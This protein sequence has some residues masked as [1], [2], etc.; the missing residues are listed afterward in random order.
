MRRSSMFRSIVA[1][2][3]VACG[4]LGAESLGG[5]RTAA[6]SDLAVDGIA[7]SDGVRG[8]G[9]RPAGPV[10]SAMGPVRLDG[11]VNMSTSGARVALPAS[12]DARAPSA[13]LDQQAIPYRVEPRGS[14]G[15]PMNAFDLPPEVP[16]ERDFERVETFDELA[17]PH[18]E[19]REEIWNTPEDLVTGEGISRYGGLAYVPF[20]ARNAIRLGRFSIFPFAHVEGVWHSDLGG[21]DGKGDSGF[22]VQA[23]AGVLAEYLAVQGRTKFKASA[24]ADYRWYSDVLDDAVTYVGGI[25]VEQR[26]LRFFTVDAGVEFERAQIPDDLNTSLA[27]D[28]NRIERLSVYANGRWDRFVSDDMR[29]E[30]GGS[31]AWIDDL[32]SS[33]RNGGDYTDLNLYGRLGYAI[34]RHESFAYGEYRYENRDA[35]GASSDLDYAHEFRLGVNGILPHGRVRRLVGNAWV[36]YRTEQYNAS[37]TAGSLGRGRDESVDLITYGGDLTYRPSPYTSANLSFSHSNAFSAVSNFNTVDTVTLGVTQN[38]SHRLI[39]R[40]AASWSRVDPQGLT[41]SH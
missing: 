10:V 8:T 34:M 9:A 37:D 35:E 19:I 33:D 2:C 27:N 30:A 15:R 5:W 4:A 3:A 32:S 31:Y 24:R 6:G 13:A 22:E 26:F 7:P 14:D 40:L 25:G 12:L 38:L 16:D 28:D 21:F 23:S 1:L 17:S 41:D 20:W 11:R 39:G 36:G 18:Y 29:L